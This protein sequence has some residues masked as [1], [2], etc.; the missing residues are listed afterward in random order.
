MNQLSASTG[1]T[2]DELDALGES[3]KNIYAQN[4]G[5]DFN[6]VAEGWPLRRK[7]AICRRSTGAGHRG[8]L[9]AA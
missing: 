6:D 3:V 2:G 7:R 8:R 9:R 4:L 1:A 5:E